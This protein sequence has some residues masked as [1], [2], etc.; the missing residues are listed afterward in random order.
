MIFNIYTSIECQWWW[1][2][3]A[4]CYQSRLRIFKWNHR[5]PLGEW[6]VTD[7]LFCS[8]L[9]RVHSSPQRRRLGWRRRWIGRQPKHRWKH[10]WDVDGDIWVESIMETSE[11]FSA[12]SAGFA[13]QGCANFCANKRKKQK[14][15]STMYDVGM[16]G[17][18]W[19]RN[20]L[21]FESFQERRWCSKVFVQLKAKVQLTWS[22][23]ERVAGLVEPWNPSTRESFACKCWVKTFRSRLSRDS[24]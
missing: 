4:K 3:N 10:H 21:R 5:E 20:G 13:S 17:N 18:P 11:I 1:P 14:S 22:S 23:R 2:R 8:A 12:A 15:F 9:Q 6:D 16:T 7:H 19:K 24:L